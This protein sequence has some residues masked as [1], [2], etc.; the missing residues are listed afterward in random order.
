MLEGHRHAVPMR[1]VSGAAEDARAAPLSA[2]PARRRSRDARREVGA[3][4]GCSSG[5]GSPTP[6][7]ARRSARACGAVRGTRRPGGDACAPWSSSRPRETAG[8]DVLR[9]AWVRCRIAPHEV[10][11][12]VL[13]CHHRGDAA[14]VGGD[15]GQVAVA[16]AQ[17]RQRVGQRQRLGHLGQRPHHRE[18]DDGVGV[19]DQ[20]QHVLDV[21]V[22]DEARRRRRRPGSGSSRSRQRLLDGAR[23]SG[24][25]RRRPPA[26][27]ASRR[28][29]S[30]RRRRP[31]CGSA[32]P[33]TAGCAP[34][35][36]AGP[37]TA[38]R[39]SSRT[40]RS[41]ETVFSS[42]FLASTPNARSAKLAH[43]S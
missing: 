17:P 11:D 28:A 43:Q 26:P 41:I 1:T 37:R 25:S 21:H 39:R 31:G 30:R 10:L 2:R 34:R 23:R 27:R 3:A 36:R 32:A 15:Q 13:E 35:G 16:A 40:A 18:V 29:G 22:A 5:T 9:H 12:E 42:S 7:V 6:D 20:R 24:R 4:A 38:T 33:A 14:V 8:E 19:V